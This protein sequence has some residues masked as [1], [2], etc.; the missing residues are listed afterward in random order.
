MARINIANKAPGREARVTFDAKQVDEVDDYVKAHAPGWWVDWDEPTTKSAGN[1]L[2]QPMRRVVGRPTRA[3]AS[4][5]KITIRVTDAERAAWT[6][7]ASDLSLGE[8]IREQ[9]NTAAK[10]RS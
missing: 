5:G 2:S 9:C 7:E 3:G 10:V 1:R 8:W 6:R 4:T